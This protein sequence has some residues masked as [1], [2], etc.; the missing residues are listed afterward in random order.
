MSLNKVL[1]SITELWTK[2]ALNLTRV[3][4]VLHN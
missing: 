2:Q 4:V 1:Q 3:P